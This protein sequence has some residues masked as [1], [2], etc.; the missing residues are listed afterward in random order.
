MHHE[1]DETDA[2]YP[3]GKESGITLR[4]SAILCHVLLTRRRQSGVLSGHT[5]LFGCTT[6]HF[7]AG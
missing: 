1:P 6:S 3:P 5:N 2:V 4:F 7:V